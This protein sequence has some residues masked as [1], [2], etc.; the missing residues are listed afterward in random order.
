MGG[1][2]LQGLHWPA[3]G[4]VVVIAAAFVSSMRGVRRQQP[5]A[6]RA[7][8]VVGAVTGAG[9]ADADRRGLR[10]DRGSPVGPDPARATDGPAAAG[11]AAIVRCVRPDEPPSCHAVRRG[12]VPDIR[13]FR[14]LRYDPASIADPSLV[15]APPY[16][17]VGAAEHERLLARHPANVVRLDLPGDEL[18]DEPDDALPA[19]GPHARRHGGRTGPST[20]IRIRRSTSTSRPIASRGPTSS[21]P[22]AASSPACAW[23]RSARARASCRTSGRWPGHAR[24][25]TS[26]SGRPASTRARSSGCTTIRPAPAGPILDAL[27]ARRAGPRGDRRRRDP[28]SAVGRAADGDGGRGRGA[29]AGRRLGAAR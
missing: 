14:A 16:D 17:V 15:V 26:C 24:I 6:V 28:P 23:S 12:P 29:A 21:G 25:A 2:D 22:S 18:G 11:R 20:R 3:I 1:A 27:T 13:P 7:V 10:G 4:A 9:A 8:G 5:A 19:G